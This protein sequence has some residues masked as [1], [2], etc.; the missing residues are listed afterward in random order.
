MPRSAFLEGA[1]QAGGTKT[2]SGAIAKQKT[3]VPQGVA[4]LSLAVLESDGR[5]RKAAIHNHHREVCAIPV[6]LR[7]WSAIRKSSLDSGLN[8]PTCTD[9][10]EVRLPQRFFLRFSLL[11]VPYIYEGSS[12]RIFPW[13]LGGPDSVG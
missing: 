7:E 6:K 13:E 11:D 9:L 2:Y 8:V 4:S 12:R 1:R 3:A 10:R 5:K